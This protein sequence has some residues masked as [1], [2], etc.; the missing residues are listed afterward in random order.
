M[1]TPNLLS[2]PRAI[3]NQAIECFPTIHPTTSAPP[4]TWAARRGFKFASA[5]LSATIAATHRVTDVIGAS[6]SAEAGRWGG[7]TYL[8]PDL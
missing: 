2:R 7:G 8:V 3:L 1:Y 4:C 6:G 5:P